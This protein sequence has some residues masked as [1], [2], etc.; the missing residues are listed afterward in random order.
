MNRIA[1]ICGLVLGLSL[2]SVS[3]G[4]EK[5]AAPKKKTCCEEAIAKGG[6]CKNRCCMAAHAAGKSCEKCNPGKED[7]EAQKAAKNKKK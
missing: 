3:F 2:A 7:L 6:E 5:A 4:A 1:V